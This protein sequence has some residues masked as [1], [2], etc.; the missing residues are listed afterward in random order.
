MSEP[1]AGN[2]GFLLSSAGPTGGCGLVTDLESALH[3]GPRPRI[4][5][6]LGDFPEAA[7]PG[8]VLEKF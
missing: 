4:E 7:R 8:A 6:V 5:D 1:S 2:T 3:V